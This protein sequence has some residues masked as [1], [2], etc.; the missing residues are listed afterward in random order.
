[1]HSDRSAA[2]LNVLLDAT[3]RAVLRKGG[4][5]ETAP[6]T[7]VLPGD[8][9]STPWLLLAR[10]WFWAALVRSLKH[11]MPIVVL[12]RV[13]HARPAA[14]GSQSGLAGRLDVLF[15]RAGRF[16]R[17]PPSNCLERSL[18]AYRLLC[19]T[20]AQPELVIG[21]KRAPGD[22]L[23]GHTWVVVDGRP[24]GEDTGALAGFA[25]VLA[26]D[27]RGRQTIGSARLPRGIRVA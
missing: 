25:P 13:V 20:G 14:G 5:R 1:M 11:V 8:R 27:A 10:L 22:R 21:M 17:R 7:A 15:R 18:G 16:P 23:E 2:L 4:A 26:F 12:V 19:R 9:R 6:G 24:L 3:R